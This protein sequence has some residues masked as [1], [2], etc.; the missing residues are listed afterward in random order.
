MLLW[1]CRLCS[2]NH[3]NLRKFDVKW[4]RST[5]RP[6]TRAKIHNRRQR[7]AAWRRRRPKLSSRCTHSVSQ[8]NQ[9]SSIVGYRKLPENSGLCWGIYRGFNKGFNV[10]CVCWRYD[11]SFKY[12]RAKEWLNFLW[13]SLLSN[14]R[15]QFS[16]H[17]YNEE[18][19][20]H[21]VWC[22]VLF[23]LC[24]LRTTTCRILH[25]ILEATWWQICYL[26][27]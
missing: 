7:Q 22:P 10:C 12:V 14:G 13:Y 17:T 26:P 2:W 9:K 21:E 3:K 25:L 18:Q 11:G 15:F 16:G 6:A 19:I 5:M 8:T 23:L 24:C 27:S 4:N 20:L 1:S